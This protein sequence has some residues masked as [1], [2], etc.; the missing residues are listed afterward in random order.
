LLT[1]DSAVASTV[2]IGSPARLHVPPESSVAR[3]TFRGLAF[4]LAEKPSHTRDARHG[5]AACAGGLVEVGRPTV[6]NRPVRLLAFEV[7]VSVAFGK[8]HAGKDVTSWKVA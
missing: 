6:S 5:S 7:L 2:S 8:R 4:R 1:V 3:G